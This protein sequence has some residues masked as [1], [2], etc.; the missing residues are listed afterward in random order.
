VHPMGF[1]QFKTRSHRKLWKIF[2]KGVVH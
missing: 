1:D 2:L